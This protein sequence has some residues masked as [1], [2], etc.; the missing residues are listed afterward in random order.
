MSKR[1]EFEQLIALKVKAGLDA[2]AAVR[3]V[4]R[5]NA[6]LVEAM[7]AEANE[8]AARRRGSAGSR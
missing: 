7:N 3:A 8:G 2:G 4:V 1:D 5:E 6:E